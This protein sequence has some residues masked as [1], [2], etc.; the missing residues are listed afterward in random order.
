M[1]HLRWVP[2]AHGASRG[3]LGVT[4][5]PAPAGRHIRAPRVRSKA[6]AAVC[7]PSGAGGSFSSHSHGWRRGLQYFAAPRLERRERGPATASARGAV[8]TAVT[9][10][11]C[12]Q[13]LKGKLHVG[14]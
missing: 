3:E 14:T 8:L 6:G 13:A 10:P 1:T 5:F 4:R 2:L 12:Y 7:R 9:R 11:L